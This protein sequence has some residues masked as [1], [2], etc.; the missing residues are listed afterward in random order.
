[1]KITKILAAL[2]AILMVFSLVAC[3]NTPSVEDEDEST[4]CAY[5]ITVFDG[6]GNVFQPLGGD[7]LKV[8]I[9]SDVLKEEAIGEGYHAEAFHIP[10]D[11]E[12]QRMLAKYIESG[13]EFSAEHFSTYAVRAANKTSVKSKEELAN[14]INNGT[15]KSIMPSH[16]KRI[17]KKPK[18]K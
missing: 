16:A 17:L 6:D 1:M 13:I 8:S 15:R 11:G 9:Q 5:D 10:E 7:S 2:L 4:L 3:N 12:P 14:A 18:E